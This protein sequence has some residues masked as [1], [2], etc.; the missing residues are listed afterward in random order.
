MS[1]VVAERYCM[2]LNVAAAALGEL[3][4]RAD[5]LRRHE[6][7]RLQVRLLD[8]LELRRVGHVL[9]RVH[10]DH[11]AVRQVRVVLDARRGGE[12]VEVELALEALLHDLHVQQAEEAR[13][14]TR[15]RAR[16]SISGS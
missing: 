3:H 16:G 2:S 15:T 11:L 9:R 1:T 14:G 4:D 12:Q 5:E 10:D 8:A 6:H 13:R 7:G